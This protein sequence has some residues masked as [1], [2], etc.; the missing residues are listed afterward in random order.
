MNRFAL[1]SLSVCSFAT[2]AAPIAPMRD[3]SCL[4]LA[5]VA[6]HTADVRNAGRSEKELLKALAESR[7]YKTKFE[8][9]SARVVDMAVSYVY[10]MGYTPEQSRKMVYL[11]CKAGD[12]NN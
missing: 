1:L 10:T 7:S 9:E 6:E 4:L 3:G 5:E 12:F 11:K 8:K 2:I